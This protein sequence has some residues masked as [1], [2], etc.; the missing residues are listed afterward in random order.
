MQ[1]TGVVEETVSPMLLLYAKHCAYNAVAYDEFCKLVLST[2]NLLTRFSRGSLI[3]HEG[4]L[5][6]NIVIIS[7]RLGP[8]TAEVF[9]IPVIIESQYAV[10]RA[11]MHH[12]GLPHRPG[13]RDER[14][15]QLLISLT[16]RKIS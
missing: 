16:S 12:L 7:N 13:N 3:S 15:T 8:A 11:I 1:D 14:M 4:I 5:V 6:N 10:V 2:K 9:E